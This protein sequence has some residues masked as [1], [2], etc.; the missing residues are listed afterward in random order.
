MTAPASRPL[1]IGIAVRRS[2]KSVGAFE[3]Y[4]VE[5][6]PERQK[7]DIL[8]WVK[9]NYDGPFVLVE[10]EEDGYSAWEVNGEPRRK[11]PEFERQI[12]DIE[13]GRLDWMV[14]WKVDRSNRGYTNGARLWRACQR[15]STRLVFVNDGLDSEHPMFEQMYFWMLG[16]ARSTA[17][18]SPPGSSSIVRRSSVQASGRPLDGGSAGRPTASPRCGPTAN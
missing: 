8:E 2:K 11:R 1:R 18:G 3:Q 10:Y 15:T 16:V 13:A 5:A 7:H 12:R 9:R 14:L 17:T 4:G 6:S